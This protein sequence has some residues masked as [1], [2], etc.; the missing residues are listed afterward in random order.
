[1]SNITDGAPASLQDL[2][3]L[4]STWRYIKS[5]LNVILHTPKAGITR[6]EY[7]GLVT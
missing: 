1:M 4:Q 2:Q 6:A 7:M 3:D 5:G